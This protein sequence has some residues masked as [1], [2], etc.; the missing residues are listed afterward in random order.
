M[1]PGTPISA[2][3]EDVG[4]FQPQIRIL[5]LKQVQDVIGLKKSQ[6]YALANTPGFPQRIK[7]GT[8][9]VGYIEREV[10]AYI[11]SRVKASR[12]NAGGD[13]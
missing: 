3:A 8:R 2:S 1:K 11:E 9:A 5:R 6:I 7:L 12:D 10:Q 13:K 4:Y